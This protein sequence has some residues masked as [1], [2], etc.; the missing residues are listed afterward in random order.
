MKKIS[1]ILL[2][3]FGTISLT[4]AQVTAPPAK[5]T[6]VKQDKATIAAQKKAAKEAKAL[7]KMQAKETK[8]TP[9]PTAARLNNNGT[10][11]K[12]FS[13]NKQAAAPVAPAVRLNKNGTPDKRFSANKPPKVTPQVV[14][15]VQPTQT[16]Q[17]KPIATPAK[18]TRTTVA[19]TTTVK[20][21]DKVL[22]TD[23]KGRT[24]YQGPRGGKYYIDKNGNKEY[25]K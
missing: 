1:I 13:A 18:V 11:D 17:A 8:V 20:T 15:Q 2:L 4:I 19:H 6:V 23:A 9:A 22:T 7:A 14:P 16:M 24:I 5:A 25:I 12:R 21:A 3:M 10:P